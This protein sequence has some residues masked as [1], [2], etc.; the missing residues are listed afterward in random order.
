MRPFSWGGGSKDPINHTKTTNQKTISKC[1]IIEPI[2]QRSNIKQPKANAKTP[3]NID[4]KKSITK[5]EQ[6]LKY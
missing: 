2:L 4:A 6:M 3:I 5:A 1:K